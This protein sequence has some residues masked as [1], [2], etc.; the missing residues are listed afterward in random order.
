MDATV[1]TIIGVIVGYAISAGDR[2]WRERRTE[3]R[4]T[5]S[6]RILLGL[7][8]EQNLMLVGRLKERL[9]WSGETEDDPESAALKK[10]RTLIQSP[11]P[12]WSHEVFTSQLSAISDILQPVDVAS[13]YEHHNHI[14]AITNIRAVLTQLNQQE[15][16]EN[17]PL[18]SASTGAIPLMAMPSSVFYR[19]AADLW[20]ECKRLI[21]A[22]ERIGNPLH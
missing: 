7:E 6:V 18:R 17:A 10:A 12:P 11:L 14:D 16:V 22:L 15:R 3:R 9:R 13:V 8:I 19:N 1:T 21:E 5:K 2:W 20:E 4:R